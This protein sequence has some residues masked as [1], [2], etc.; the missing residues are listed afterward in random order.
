MPKDKLSDMESVLNIALACDVAAV[1]LSTNTRL[2]YDK[3]SQLR[4]SNSGR[5]PSGAIILSQLERVCARYFTGTS[6]KIRRTAHPSASTFKRA[7]EGW[8][9]ALTARTVIQ[10]V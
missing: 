7:V 1:E 9:P 10:P 8:L 4:S 3:L 6:V 2:L 5:G